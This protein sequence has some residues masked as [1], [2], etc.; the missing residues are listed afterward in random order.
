MM[1]DAYL[2]AWAITRR[3]GRVEMFFLEIYAAAQRRS[4]ASGTVEAMHDRWP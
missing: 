1:A 4:F 3:L 2:T